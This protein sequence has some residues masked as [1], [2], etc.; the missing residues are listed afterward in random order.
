[1]GTV[2]AVAT[3]E[4]EALGSWYEGAD[5]FFVIAD[6]QTMVVHDERPFQDGWVFQDEGDQ[7]RNGHLLKID[8]LFHHDFASTGNDVIAPILAFLEDFHQIRRGQFMGKD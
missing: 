6:L 3:R 5:L 4:G 1:M 7:F 2:G 8:I